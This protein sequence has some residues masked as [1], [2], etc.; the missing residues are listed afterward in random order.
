ML[1]G[2]VMQDLLGEGIFGLVGMECRYRSRSSRGCSGILAGTE[3]GLQQL[4]LL[5][6]TAIRAGKGGGGGV[7][8][9]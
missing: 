5:P 2:P 4:D 6:Y 8:M 1:N 9:C 7:L 3:G